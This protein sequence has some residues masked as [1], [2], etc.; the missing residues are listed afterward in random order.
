MANEDFSGYTEVDPN[1]NIVVTSSRSTFTNLQRN[2]D[3]YVYKD[4]GAGHFDG[5]FEHL[6]TCLFDNYTSSGKSTIWGIANEVNDMWY[7][8]DTQKDFLWAFFYHGA[9]N[10]LYLK[11]DG[12]AGSVSDSFAPSLDTPYYLKIKRDENVGDYGTLYCYIYSDEARTNLLDTLSITLHAKID[13]RYIYVTQSANQG[14]PNY[15][16]IGYS[17]NLDLQEE[18]PPVGAAIPVLSK[19]GIHSLVF[20]GQIIAG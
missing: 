1:S 7:F 6:V 14:T 15:L 10:V 4:K 18:A 3:A 19:D 20:G 8:D 11:E 9:S 13:F 12:P 2:E 17:E 5:D 16:I